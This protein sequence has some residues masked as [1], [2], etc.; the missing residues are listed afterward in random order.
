[1]KVFNE[2]TLCLYSVTFENWFTPIIERHLL[3][4]NFDM[5]LVD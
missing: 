4:Q 5:K 2:G 1:M 3:G